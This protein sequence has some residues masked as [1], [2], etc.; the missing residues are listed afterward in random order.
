MNEDELWLSDEIGDEDDEDF[1][2]PSS[3][4]MALTYQGPPGEF[5]TRNKQG[6]R[7][8]PTVSSFRAGP[9]KKPA[10]TVSCNA[11]AMVHGEM[12]GFSSKMATLLIY[13]FQFRS[14]RG[15]RLKEADILFEFKPLPGATGRV[16]VAQVRPDGVHKMERTEQLE[17]HSVWAGITGAPMQAIGV[18]VGAD[19]T[20]EK[21]TGH[22]TV[23]TGDRPQD[24][25]GDYYEARFA[26]YENKSQGDGIPSKLTACIL[27][28]RD[29]DQDFV[30]VPTISVKPNFTTA[31]ATLFSSRDPDDPVYF[32]VDEPP[33]DLLEGRVKIDPTNLAATRLDE[34][35]DCTMYNNYQGA[36]KP[37]Q[38]SPA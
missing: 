9:R 24:D 22:H 19:R 25:W 36:V 35:W 34:A 10:F 15:A 26:L 1:I 37:S 32:N 38:P 5:R 28:E 31:V 21:I 8:R 16:S 23:V 7:Q 30:C 14:Y 20:V 2:G 13:E 29:D 3:F 33:V 11:K 6:Q 4:T 18:E 17:G 12:G 27:L